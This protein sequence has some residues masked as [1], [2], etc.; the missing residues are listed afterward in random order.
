M[1]WT[2]WDRP[3]CTGRLCPVICRR[4]GCFWVTAQI[5]QS[6]RCRASQ[7]HRWATK[8]SNKSSMVNTPT[9]RFHSVWY[10][11]VCGLLTF[12]TLF[13]SRVENVPVR[14][15]DVDYRLLEAAK[16]GDLDTVKV[17]IYINLTYIS[18]AHDFTVTLGLLMLILMLLFVVFT[19]R[20]T[21]LLCTNGSAIQSQSDPDIT[22]LL[23]SLHKWKFYYW[24]LFIYLFFLIN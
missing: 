8:L 15:S 22:R 1:P 5:Q 12:K 11:G 23:T 6:S 17:T 13:V 4:V 3:L 10:L 14:N 18:I 2:L 20:Q 7:L 21:C 19:E 9:I 16:A 24:G